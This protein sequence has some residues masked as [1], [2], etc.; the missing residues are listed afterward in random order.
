MMMQLRQRD[1]RSGGSWVGI[2]DCAWGHWRA[3]I[4]DVDISL[5]GVY[6]WLL[7]LA[8]TMT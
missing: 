2:V 7:V 1:R 8:R 5:R 3:R 4:G 6:T